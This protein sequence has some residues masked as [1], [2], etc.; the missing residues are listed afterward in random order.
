MGGIFE[1]AFTYENESRFGYTPHTPYF[2]GM[3]YETRQK[4]TVP[5]ALSCRRVNRRRF[6]SPACQQERDASVA[7]L[8]SAIGTAKLSPMA[9][10]LKG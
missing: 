2:S 4:R 1:A 10:S 6:V 3:V 8:T 5:L 7:R 9:R